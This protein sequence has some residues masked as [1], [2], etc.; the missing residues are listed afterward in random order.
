M[1][2]FCP[3]FFISFGDDLNKEVEDLTKANK[4]SNKVTSKQRA[5][6]FQIPRGRGFG[7]MGRGKQSNWKGRGHFLGSGR[8]QSGNYQKYQSRQNKQQQQQK[9]Q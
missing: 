8:G 5:E 7:G 4:L 9:S 1:Q 2:P 6:P 3:S